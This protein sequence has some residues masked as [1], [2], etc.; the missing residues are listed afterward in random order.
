MRNLL[1]L[2]TVLALA[3]VVLAVPVLSGAVLSPLGLDP[4]SCH[5]LAGT[6]ERE[7]ARDR[8]LKDQN[9]TLLARERAMDR[10]ARDLAEGRLDLAEAGGRLRD[11]ASRCPDFLWDRFREA[12]PAGSDDE[13]FCRQ[14]LILACNFLAGERREEEA[15]RLE[16]ELRD[17]LDDGTLRLRDPLPAEAGPGA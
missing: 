12:N 10:V 5:D 14:A 16:E 6:L 4:V 17:R 7:R 8:A 2:P 15:G 13:R 3:A 1:C 9:A 11:I